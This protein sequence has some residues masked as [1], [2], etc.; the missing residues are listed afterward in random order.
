MTSRTNMNGEHNT[1]RLPP[2]T[3]HNNRYYPNYNN[4]TSGSSSSSRASFKG[5]CCCL[6]LLL[7]FLGLLVLAVILII[8]LAVKPKKPQFELQQ[9]GV[10]YVGIAAAAPIS[11]TVPSASLSFNIRMVFT[12]VNPNKVGIKYSPTEFDVMYRGV[13]LGRA[14][15]PGFYQPAHSVRQVETTVGVDRVNLLQAEATDLVKDATLYD[16]VE[17]RITGDV[18]AKIRILDFT[19]P[20]VKVS[21]DCAIVISPRKSSLT[22]KQCGV[23]GLKV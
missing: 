8:V 19:S 4:F 16:R 3:A 23:D 9:V 2:S 20:R 14:S 10:Q 17:L 12:A 15:V 22:Y 1:S 11:S 18:G 13:P 7:T 5:C 21:V 6:F